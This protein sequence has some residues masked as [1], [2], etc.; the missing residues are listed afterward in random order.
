[1]VMD[2]KLVENICLKNVSFTYS[3]DLKN[4]EI[5]T[6]LNLNIKPGKVNIIIGSSGAGKSTLIKLLLGF[7]QPVKGS[8]SL[9][10]IELTNSMLLSWRNKIA[11]V[12]QNP[13]LFFGTIADN[14][15]YGNPDANCN[16]I[17]EAAKSAFIHK[18]I[19]KLPDGYNTQ[20]NEIGSNLSGGQRQ[21][22]TIARAL[23]REAPILLFDEFSS[24]LDKKSEK[25]IMEIL[26]AYSLK[27]ISLLITHRLSIIKDTYNC[28]ELKDKCIM[29]KK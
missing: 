10:N 27:H 3:S 1:M 25:Y 6:A 23:L 22:L 24:A 2:N 7:Y 28:F 19:E 12:P 29:I 26:E 21:R 20:I 14:I 18:D 11:Y 9:N 15:Q 13:F 16:Q 8:I 5:L 4:N 17:I